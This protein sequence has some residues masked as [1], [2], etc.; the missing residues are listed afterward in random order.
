MRAL[1]QR[2]SRAR[3]VVDDETTGQ[4]GPGL[5]ALVGV[6]HEDG[7]PE[8]EKLARKLW[9]LRVFEDE[10]GAMNLAVADTSGEVLVVSQF[11]LYG[12]TRKGRRPSFVDAARPEQAE[13]LVAEVVERLRG[14]GARVGVGRFGAHMDVELVNHGPVTLLVEV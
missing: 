1:V 12:D 3:V 14:L 4:I 5:L 7:A 10:A 13:R 9:G 8:A 2:V 6:T 11:T